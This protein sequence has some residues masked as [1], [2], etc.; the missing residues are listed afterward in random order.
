[1]AE[2]TTP[3]IEL[4]FPSDLEIRM[5]RAFDA[6]RDLVFEAHSKCEH[7]TNWWGRTGSTLSTCE[8]E[9]RP[10][11]TWRFVER[12]QNGEE[13]GF[14]GAFREIVRPERIIWTFEFDGMPGKVSVDTLTFSERAGKTVLT[15]TSRFGSKED[16][17]GMAASRMEEGANETWDR[18]AEYLKVIA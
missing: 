7:L 1:M 11:G 10:G 6:P 3:N 5:V 16:R 14:R 4:S 13:Y 17:D 18:L 8:L 12:Q 2:P 15:A 9:F